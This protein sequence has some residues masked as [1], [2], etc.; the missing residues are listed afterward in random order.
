MAFGF[1]TRHSMF[2]SCVCNRNQFSVSLADNTTLRGKRGYGNIFK[3]NTAPFK[4]RITFSSDPTPFFSADPHPTDHGEDR[5][6]RRHFSSGR[7]LGVVR[8][9]LPVTLFALVL[10]GLATES[11]HGTGSYWGKKEIRTRK[12][13]RGRPERVFIQ[14]ISTSVGLRLPLPRP[15]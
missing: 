2:L 9:G 3:N 14:M 13:G 6:H 1:A 8:C 10:K 12:R 11:R 5:S 4:V 15:Y 7:P